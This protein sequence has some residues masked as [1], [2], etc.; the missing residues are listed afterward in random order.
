MGGSFGQNDINLSNQFRTFVTITREQGVIYAN[1][2]LVLTFTCLKVRL[3]EQE[4][5]KTLLKIGKD[6][7]F[8]LLLTDHE[9]LYF[10]RKIGLNVCFQ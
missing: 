10:Y 8:F 3:S 9:D 4:L 6:Y 7:K 1:S 2:Q 5:A